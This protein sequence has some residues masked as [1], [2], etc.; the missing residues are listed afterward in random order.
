VNIVSKF[1]IASSIVSGARAVAVAL[2]GIEQVLR[3][4]GFVA[5]CGDR[6]RVPM[7]REEDRCVVEIG[8]A[9]G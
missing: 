2:P 6:I 1:G 9:L 7:S 4:A 5:Y 3:R 8:V